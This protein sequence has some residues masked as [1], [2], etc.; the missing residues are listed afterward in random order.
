MIQNIVF[1]M[2][3]VLIAFDAGRY[4]TRFVP[5]PADYELI[6][7]EL[8]RSVEW[9]RLD[10]GAMTSGEVAA[11]VCARLP[12]RL[13]GSV[14]QILDNWHRDIP[15]LEGMYELVRELKDNGYPLYLLSNTSVEFH[16]FRRQIPALELFDQVFISA[17]WH[18]LKPEPAIY[19]VFLAHFRL[20]AEECV[21][22]D[23]APLNVEAALNAGMDGIVYHGDTADLRRKLRL[24]GVRVKESGE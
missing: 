9:V 17:D 11:S 18:L 15:P 12:E 6:R 1:D 2:G 5:D 24:L 10:R 4:I 20:K 13:H 3:R 8:F 16:E 19:G 21:F 14:A 22:I 7:R 23:D